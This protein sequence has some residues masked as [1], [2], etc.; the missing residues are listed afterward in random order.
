MEEDDSN[1]QGPPCLVALR[2]ARSGRYVG[3]GGAYTVGF[4]YVYT[5]FM[6]ACAGTYVCRW[7][8]DTKNKRISTKANQTPI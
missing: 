7:A 4:G 6:Y 3:L 2:S 5:F 1:G 8:C